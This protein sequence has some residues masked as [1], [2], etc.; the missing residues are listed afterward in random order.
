MSKV[1]VFVVSDSLG[2]TAHRVAHAA[3]SQFGNDM[4]FRRV[5]YVSARDA[6]DEVV[7]DARGLRSLV[8]H[9][10]VLPEFRAHIN[11]RCRAEGI[12]AIDI[13]GPMMD[14]FST[15]CESQPKLQPGLIYQLDEQYFREV[16]A[17]E[18]AVKYDDGKDPRG[19]LKAEIV[20]LGVSRTSKTPLSMYIAHRGYRVANVP[21]V[22]EVS[23]P[24]EIYLVPRDR[25]FGLTIRAEELQSIRQERLKALGLASNASYASFERINEELRYGEGIMRAAGCRIIDVTKRAVEETASKIIEYY[26][27]RDKL[28]D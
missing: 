24:D 10:L 20:L 12:A 27:R 18:F 17:V 28:G 4:D 14:G 25:I 13:L 5:S 7:E 2:E 6:L 22:P 23:P 8:V 3:A 9:T 16:E 15:I 19:L 26:N 1:V 21:L 11:A